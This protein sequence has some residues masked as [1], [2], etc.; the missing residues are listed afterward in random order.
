MHQPIRILKENRIGQVLQP[1]LIPCQRNIPAVNIARGCSFSCVYC[2]ARGYSNAPRK[3]EVYVYSNL[4][5]KL[6]Q[7]LENPRRRKPWP[8]YVSLNTSTDSFQPYEEVLA[9]S[10]QVMQLLLQRN[11]GISLLTKGE[12][13]PEFITLFQ[14]S[15]ERVAVAIGLVSLSEAFK[16]RYEPGAASINDR[17]DTIARLTR[18]GINVRV[19]LDPLIPGIND[20][21]AE[22]RD[23][24]QE[25]SCRGVNTVSVSYLMMRPGIMG[26]IKRELPAVH[27]KL[28]EGYFQYRPR[29][30]I[31][32]SQ[33]T[34]LIS[35]VLRLRRYEEIKALAAEH[36]LKVLICSCKNPGLAAD[37]C[38]QPEQE[39]LSATRPSNNTRQLSLF[40]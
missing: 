25:L 27:Y 24:F 33:N 18:A 16:T 10:W 22:I 39:F 15:K 36:Q 21:P 1:P 32:A 8:R 3:D 40:K 29:S 2:Y 28:L 9:I 26:Q 7:E 23:L 17:L 34:Q 13:P 11:I 19:R 30:F 4:A 14:R 6:I 38:S 35:P 12:I 31:A 20:T 5:E 37:L